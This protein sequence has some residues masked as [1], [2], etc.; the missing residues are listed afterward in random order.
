MK[1]TSILK[2]IS[3]SRKPMPER[4]G[5]Q[6]FEYIGDTPI[7]NLEIYQRGNVQIL[8]DAR[9]DMIFCS[10]LVKEKINKSKLVIYLKDGD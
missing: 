10:R 8:Y 7:S 5:E 3:E 1:L 4:L 9:K 6:G 2:K